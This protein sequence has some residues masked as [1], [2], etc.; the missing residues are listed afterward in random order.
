MNMMKNANLIQELPKVPLG[1]TGLMVSRLSFGTGS[2]GWQGR[3]NQSELGINQLANLLQLGYE[4]GVNFW[5][6]A[7]AYGTHPHIARALQDIPRSEVVILTK[8]M[9]Q[10]AE[11]VSGVGGP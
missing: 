2:N 5:D 9:S 4:H 1:N 8:T 10:K 11:R 6:S 7:D 3:S